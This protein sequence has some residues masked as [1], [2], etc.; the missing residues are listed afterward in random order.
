MRVLVSPRRIAVLADGVPEEQ[1][2]QVQE[3]RGPKAEVAYAEDG[4]LTKAG[5]GFARSKGAAAEDVR[6]EVVDG[7]EFVVRQRR[8]RAS[9]GARRRARAG[10]APHHRPADPA[11]HALGRQ[12]GGRERVPAVLAPHPLAR[13]QARRRDPERR[14]LRPPIGDASRGTACSAS[15]SRSPGLP[16]TSSLLAEQKV[17]VSQRERERLIREGLDAAAAELDGRV[18]GP[19][20]R[21]L[22]GH[23]PGRVA[24]RRPRHLQGPAPAAARRG[25]G[26]GR[27]ATCPAG[28]VCSARR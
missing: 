9:R 13:R 22:R 26:D 16:T 27:S 12:A 18:V 25:P 21:A 20:R 4:T 28:T 1:L 24:Q 15:R 8:G 10:R 5:A 17:I 19:R 2:A 14:V 3:F 7:T 11:R 6:R 23:L